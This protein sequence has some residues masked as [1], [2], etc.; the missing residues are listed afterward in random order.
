[1]DILLN[2]DRDVELDDR[3]DLATVEGR[4]A[5]EQSI[6][7]LVTQYFYENIGSLSETNAVERIKIEAENVVDEKSYVQGVEAVEV[8]RVT[9]EKTN[10]AS[11][12]VT[13]IYET[14]ETESFEV[15][16]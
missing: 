1:M 13:L 10:T 8:E 16:E 4:R 7:L 14:G 5:V 12:E 9:N 15:R 2:K 6:G 3:N 11:A